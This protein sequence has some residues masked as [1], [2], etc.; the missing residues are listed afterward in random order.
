MANNC[1]E[2]IEITYFTLLLLWYKILTIY[3]QKEQN[4]AIYIWTYPVVILKNKPEWALCHFIQIWVSRLKKLYFQ[5]QWQNYFT[6]TFSQFKDQ[7]VNLAV[8]LTFI[9]SYLTLFRQCSCLNLIFQKS[10]FWELVT[11]L[12]KHSC[13]NFLHESIIFIMYIIG[14]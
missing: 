1:Q 4:I 12:K 10:H 5:R 2:K 11:K 13:E 9:K 8:I 3:A 14:T 7:G 6:Q